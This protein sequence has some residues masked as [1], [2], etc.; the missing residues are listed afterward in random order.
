M[1]E[2]VDLGGFNR[3]GRQAAKDLIKRIGSRAVRGSMRPFCVLLSSVL[4]ALAALAVHVSSRNP[5][6]AFHVSSRN[7]LAAFHVSSR[8]PLAALAVHVSSEARDD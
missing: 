5:L 1:N 7:P 3:Q 6:A 8:N 4:A 2:V